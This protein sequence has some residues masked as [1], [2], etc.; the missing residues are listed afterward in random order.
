M[1]H[2]SEVKHLIT[3]PASYQVRPAVQSLSSAA[4]RLPQAQPCQS[5]PRAAHEGQ[6]QVQR[7]A[8]SL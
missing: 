4:R 7:L 8:V 1:A 3:C 6:E 5:G 2:G